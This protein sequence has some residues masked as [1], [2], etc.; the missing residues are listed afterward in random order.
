MCRNPLGE[1]Y[2]PGACATYSGH[3]LAKKLPITIVIELCIDFCLKSMGNYLSIS[4]ALIQCNIPL[5]AAWLG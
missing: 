1:H 5:F 3:D 4:P 2:S